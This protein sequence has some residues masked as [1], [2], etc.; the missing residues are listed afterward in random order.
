MSDN[1]SDCKDVQQLDLSFTASRNI[2]YAL[3]ISAMSLLT[4]LFEEA[5]ARVHVGA[6]EK[7][8]R[9]SLSVLSLN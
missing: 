4:I 9:A 3:N 1:A 5:P 2:K 8:F 6:Y 7:M